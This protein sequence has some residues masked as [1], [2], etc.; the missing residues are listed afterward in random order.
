VVI[1]LAAG[2]GERFRAAGGMQHKLDAPLGQR[3][4]KEHVLHAVR[5][6]GLPWHVV[7]AAHTAHL[8]VQGMG[9]S[10]ATGVKATAKAPGWLILPA[11]LPLIRAD[12]LQHVA[13]ALQ[14]HTVVVP[15]VQ[16]Q[17]GH[18]VGFG[19]ACRDALQQLSGDQGAKSVMQM[20]APFGLCV[21][22]I[23]CILDVDT[24]EALTQAQAL[25]SKER[26]DLST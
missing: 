6:S 19:A 24:P 11:D 18:P 22:D 9:S 3:T 7:E 4:V 14:Q 8:P 16:G 1:V 20:Y 25:W 26:R 12:T 17:A 10:I 23:G 15:R 21:D 2:L 5:S 13:Q